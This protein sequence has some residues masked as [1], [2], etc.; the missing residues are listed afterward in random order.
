MLLYELTFFSTKIGHFNSGNNY[1]RAGC[2]EVVEKKSAFEKQK[3]VEQ[4][5][6]AILDYII[7]LRSFWGP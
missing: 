1:D 3:E 2:G 6:K 4:K 5:F 7:R